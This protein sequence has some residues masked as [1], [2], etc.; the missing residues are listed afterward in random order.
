MWFDTLTQGF[1]FTSGV[2]IDLLENLLIFNRVSLMAVVDPNQSPWGVCVLDGGTGLAMRRELLMA[3][4][5][6]YFGRVTDGVRLVFTV[7]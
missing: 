7:R 5:R 1:I 6:A 3:P 2:A 4:F